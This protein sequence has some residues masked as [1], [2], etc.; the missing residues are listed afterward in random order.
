MFKNGQKVTVV[1]GAGPP[2]WGKILMMEPSRPT[3]ALVIQID[4]D[5]PR[6]ENSEFYKNTEFAGINIFVRP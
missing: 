6:P 2:L 1:F 5:Q 4:K 3:D